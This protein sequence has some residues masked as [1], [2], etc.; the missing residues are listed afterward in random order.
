M[1]DETFYTT[2]MRLAEGNHRCHTIWWFKQESNLLRQR[3]RVYNPA[4]TPISLFEP[5]NLSSYKTRI[6]LFCLSLLSRGNLMCLVVKTS[7]YST[8]ST[9]F[10]GLSPSTGQV[11]PAFALLT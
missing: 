1:V 7:R 3:H 8:N 5:K 6:L 9:D 4:G 10:H 11:T 2:V